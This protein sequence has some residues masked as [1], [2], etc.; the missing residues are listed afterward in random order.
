MKNKDNQ[1]KEWLYRYKYGGDRSI[2][3][4]SDLTRLKR[5]EPIDYIIGWSDFFGCRIGLDTRPLI[6]RA[7]T[8]YWTEKAVREIDGK[9]L[10][11]L[12][13]FA[14]SGCVGISVLKH[15]PNALV[16]FIEKD[17]RLCWQIERNCI[18]NGISLER[19]RI[20]CSDIFEVF[21]DAGGRSG[22][23]L[24]LAN[25]PYIPRERK[26]QLDNSVT[27]WE[28]HLALFA[29]EDGLELIKKFL[30][31]TKKYLNHDGQIWLEFDAEQKKALERL[32]SVAG[33][34]DMSF[35]NDQ[36]DRPRWVIFGFDKMMFY[37]SLKR[38]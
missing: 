36:Y 3:L 24:I 14:G 32:L 7:E 8:E 26:S 21:E 17:E 37:G 20:I 22:Y 34:R 15:C 5:G 25:P 33:Y 18:L 9:A 1:N 13:I 6:P 19:Y 27:D 38:D 4:S 12:D 10:R 23:D 16:D 2:D 28:P 30:R 11:V 29:G 31:Q 35:H